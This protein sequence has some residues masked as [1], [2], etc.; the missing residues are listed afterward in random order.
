MAF[1]IGEH[2]RFL[3]SKELGWW[4]E[5]NEKAK[6]GSQQRTSHYLTVM[7]E[8]E[9]LPKDTFKF[10]SQSKAPLAPVILETFLLVVGEVSRA[11]K[12]TFAGVPSETGSF[13]HQRSVIEKYLSFG[14]VPSRLVFPDGKDQP[15]NIV[16]LLNAANLFY[17]ERLDLLI[18]NIDGGQSDCL[19]CRALWAERVE[20]WTSKALEDI[21]G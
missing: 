19:E 6:D 17:L 10:Q 7:A 14:V 12:E 5:I 21:A 16:A 4:E 8:A 11:V 13:R 15:P 18:A 9:G 3:K 1:R 20:M 2:V